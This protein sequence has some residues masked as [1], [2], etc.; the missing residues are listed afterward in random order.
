MSRKRGTKTRKKERK[1]MI[2]AWG[3]NNSII[4]NTGV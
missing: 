3:Q 1:K 4:L 2:V